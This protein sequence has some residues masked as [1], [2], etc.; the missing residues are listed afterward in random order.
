MSFTLQID[1]KTT[2]TIVITKSAPTV[3]APGNVK[4]GDTARLPRLCPDSVDHRYDDKIGKMLE[5]QFATYDQLMPQF[6]SYWLVSS[7]RF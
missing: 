3:V 5:I 1:V 2:D 7:T 4:G 6:N